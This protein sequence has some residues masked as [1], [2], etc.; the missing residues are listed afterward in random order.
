MVPFC[1]IALM[2]VLPV[3]VLFEGYSNKLCKWPPFVDGSSAADSCNK[4]LLGGHSHGREPTEDR[5]KGNGAQWSEHAPRHR[6]S[7]F[8]MPQVGF[9]KMCLHECANTHVKEQLQHK[10]PNVVLDIINRIRTGVCRRSVGPVHCQAIPFAERGASASA[11]PNST[12]PRQ[13][14]NQKRRQK[15]K[16]TETRCE[17]NHYLRTRRCGAGECAVLALRN[18]CKASTRLS[19]AASK[20]WSRMNSEPNECA[21]SD[22][23]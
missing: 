14:E 3:E 20:Q 6:K 4:R 7:A 8:V 16:N 18:T 10:V 21:C 17:T 1:E 9:F 19:H 22:L 13:T 5:I 23:K 12:K 11:G 15:Q 2:A